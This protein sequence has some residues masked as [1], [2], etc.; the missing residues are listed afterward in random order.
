[1]L[2]DRKQKF[3]PY[4]EYLKNKLHLKDW[5]FKILDDPPRDNNI[6]AAIFTAYGRKRLSIYLSESFLSDTEIEQRHTLIHE[7]IHA[8]LVFACDFACEQLDQRLKDV[9]I[10]MIEYGVDGIADSIAPFFKLPN[11]IIGS[12]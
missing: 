11:E 9:F 4:I 8:H 3:V 7:L 12:S 2:D 5:E 1:M 10:R 6:I